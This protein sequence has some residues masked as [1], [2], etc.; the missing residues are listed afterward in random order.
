MDYGYI[1]MYIIVYIIY[2]YIGV[3]QSQ[4]LRAY[5]ICM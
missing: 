2:I 3:L 1:H 4:D 5:C